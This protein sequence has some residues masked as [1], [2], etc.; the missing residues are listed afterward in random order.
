MLAAFRRLLRQEG[1]FVHQVRG[2]P[3]SVAWWCET[4]IES[5]CQDATKELGVSL[6]HPRINRAHCRLH[7]H[8]IDT[9]RVLP[10][11]IATMHLPPVV[12]IS[13]QNGK[14]GDRLGVIAVDSI[15]SAVF[16]EMGYAPP[17]R[18]KNVSLEYIHCQCGEYH[19]HVTLTE[20][21]MSGDILTP[22]SF[23][24][25]KIFCQFDGSAHRAKTI[26]GAGAA[27]YVLSEQGLQL[28]DWSCLSIPKCPDNIVAEVLG[29]DLSLRLYERYVHGCLSHNSVPLPLD[30]IQGEILPLLSNLRFQTRFRRPDLVAVINRFHTKRSRLAPSSATEYRPREANF[31]ADYLAGRGST[32]LLHHTEDSA[33]FQGI[34]EHDIDPPYELLLQHNASIFGKHA[35]GKTILVLREAPACSALTLSQVVPQ[36]DEHTQRLLCDLALATQKLTRRHVVEYVAAA[37]DGHGRLYAKQ[38][39]AQYLPKQVRTFIYAQTHQE[40]DMAGAHYELIRRFVNSSSLPHIEVLRTTLAAIWGE[41]CCIGSENVIKMFPV[42]VINAGAPATLRFLQQH[43]LQVAGFVSTIACD[44]DTAKAVCADAVL[45]HR[46]DL[47]TTFTNRY[48]YACEYLEMQV[49]SKF[50]KAIQMRYRCASI[51][52]PHD[53]VWLDTVVSAA[54]IAKAEQEAVDDVFPC[55]THTERLFRTRSLAT[56]YAQAV[57]LFSN[58]PTTTYIFPAHP[59]PPPLRTS[60]KKPAAIFHDRRH[61]S[62][63]DEVYHERMRK[64]TRRR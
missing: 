6:M 17:E 11:D 23:G 39:C 14:A 56:D 60:R 18:R 13:L 27:M 59:V 52:W 58:T 25:P 1:A 33:A 9:V 3:K 5:T 20:H 63:H 31:I 4:L 43:C 46:A 22:C 55:C 34:I 40:V 8:L 28:L 37:T 51:I 54:D 38:S 53:G 49:M 12:N 41:N 42:R 36:V 48:Y 50:V 47:T 29:A 45:R 30:R 19:V 32:F 21:V 62:E 57:E 61:Q 24:P 15:H 35:A 16:R 64:R 2:E 44:L 26:G 7:A 10:T